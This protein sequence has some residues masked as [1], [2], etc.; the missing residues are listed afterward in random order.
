MVYCCSNQEQNEHVL[1]TH[2]KV[3]AMQGDSPSL[4]CIDGMDLRFDGYP[5]VRA[6]TSI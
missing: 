6:I 2:L 5:N 1:A 4:G 3:L